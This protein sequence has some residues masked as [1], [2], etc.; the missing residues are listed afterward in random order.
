MLC[1]ILVILHDIYS[2]DEYVNV[3]ILLNHEER[4]QLKVLTHVI[5]WVRVLFQ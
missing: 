4:L 3:D 2:I 1:Q 5:Y